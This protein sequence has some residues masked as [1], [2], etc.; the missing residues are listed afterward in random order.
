MMV[1]R[2]QYLQKHGYLK[3]ETTLLEQFERLEKQ[4]Y[5]QRNLMLKS[6]MSENRKILQPLLKSLED[7]M[8]E[9]KALIKQLILELQ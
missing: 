4:S 7:M 5:T 3:E 9:E 8:V 1:A 6:F 2:V